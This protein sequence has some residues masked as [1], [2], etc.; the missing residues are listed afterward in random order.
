MKCSWTHRTLYARGITVTLPAKFII[1]L[2]KW[3]NL[4]YFLQI[5]RIFGINFQFSVEI[6]FL[7][8]F[9]I[10]SLDLQMKSFSENS[11][12]CTISPRNVSM[13]CTINSE[14]IYMN[15]TFA[16]AIIKLKLSI[17]GSVVNIFSKRNIYIWIVSLKMKK[18]K[19]FWPNRHALRRTSLFDRPTECIEH[20]WMWSY[21]RYIW[22]DTKYSFY[23]S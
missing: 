4:Q 6:W 2:K 13:S 17:L 22:S 18:K 11:V 5:K 19:I 12:N 10:Y 15:F 16:G 8:L 14:L 7:H 23:L 1:N 9:G 20:D 21:V 3:N